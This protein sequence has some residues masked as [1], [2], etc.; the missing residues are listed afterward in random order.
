MGA[1]FSGCSQGPEVAPNW[2]KRMISRGLGFQT[3]ARGSF[4]PQG[5]SGALPN[6]PIITPNRRV[7]HRQPGGSGKW[8]RDLFSWS[9]SCS[10]LMVDVARVLGLHLVAARPRRR[11]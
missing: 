10:Q 9:P 2:P 1:L 7:S 6:R 4:E 11:P 3:H 5:L 8:R